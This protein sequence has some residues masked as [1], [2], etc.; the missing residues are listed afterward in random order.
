MQDWGLPGFPLS[1]WVWSLVS[2]LFGSCLGGHAGE[3]LW[4]TL[5]GDTVSQQT[6]GSPGSYI[7][8]ASS[9]HNVPWALSAGGNQAFCSNTCFSLDQHITDPC[10]TSTFVEMIWRREAKGELCWWLFLAE[11]AHRPCFLGV[12]S[13]GLPAANRRLG[14]PFPLL[15]TKTHHAFT[16][17]SL[18]RT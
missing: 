10:S 8:A 16:P 4:L 12:K 14:F 9:S 5:I 2:S 13:P 11:I 7:L 17:I 15:R 1:S 3:T 6:L 18:N